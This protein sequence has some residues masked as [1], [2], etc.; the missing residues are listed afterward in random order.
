MTTLS[1]TLQN[2]ESVFSQQ[3]L[4]EY[5]DKALASILV[6]CHNCLT[7]LGKIVHSNDQLDAANV[8]G[9]RDKSRRAWQRLTMDPHTEKLQSSIILYISLSTMTQ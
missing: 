5:E 2:I 6:P 1:S 3:G 4:T 9:L 7:E 8:H